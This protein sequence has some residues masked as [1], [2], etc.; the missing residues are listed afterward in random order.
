[1]SLT[2]KAFLLKGDNS[3]PEI[4]RVSIPADVTSSYEYLFKKLA[5]IFSSLRRSENFSLYWKD[6]DGDLVSFSTDEELLEALGYINDNIFRVYIKEKK[7]KTRADEAEDKGQ[8]HPGVTCDGCEM[9]VVGIRFKCLVCPDYD[10]CSACEGKGT[11]TEHDMTKISCPVDFLGMFG[12]GKPSCPKGRGRGRHGHGARGRH[13]GPEVPSADS[14]GSQ[15]PG[16]YGMWGSQGPFVPPPHFR[17]WMQKCMKRW[18]GKTT[19]NARP[20]DAGGEKSA[21]SMDNEDKETT[22]GEDFL[23]TIG[24]QVAAMLDPFGIDVSVDVDSD[25]N[26]TESPSEKKEGHGRKHGRGGRHQR[27]HKQRSP[28]S[29]DK[30]MDTSNIET[31]NKACRAQNSNS[32]DANLEE[33]A[34]KQ[35][36]T[37]WTILNASNGQLGT[38]T[39]SEPSLAPQ[40]PLVYPTVA[41][42]ASAPPDTDNTVSY[43]PIDPRLFAALQQMLAMGFSNEGGWLARLLEAK[44]GNIDQVL[45]T[46]QKGRNAASSHGY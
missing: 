7:Q 43:P 15:E 14:E 44:K 46:I 9:P 37:E 12:M 8:F 30:P 17:R 10:L 39:T 21:Q 19:P 26:K 2:V 40:V 22:Q 41:P 5:D 32:L 1:M 4:R 36:E 3:S 35:A 20:C 25:E 31:E 42:H 28:S 27:C 6:P 24:E 34:Q 45:D 38:P 13:C 29:T 11:H 16:S 33:A 23:R 18:H